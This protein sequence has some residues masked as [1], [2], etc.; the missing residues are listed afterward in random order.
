MVQME[1]EILTAIGAA[2]TTLASFD[3]ALSKV[4]LHEANLITLSSVMPASATIARRPYTE[5]Q[6]AIGDRLFCVLSCQSSPP[7]Q[8]AV[9]GLA[10]CQ[11]E[12]GSGIFL[13]GHGTSEDEVYKELE[14]GLIDMLACRPTR[15]WG[16]FQFEIASAS[17]ADCATCAIVMA[18]YDSEDW[19]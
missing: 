17:P 13:E 2:R 10:W 9:A 8:P 15:R 3:V 4:G 12:D 11:S 6:Y 7:W 18:V 1:I 19:S 14:F 16:P 5:H